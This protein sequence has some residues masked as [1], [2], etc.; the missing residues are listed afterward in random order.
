MDYSTEFR[1]EYRAKEKNS[2]FPYELIQEEINE[3]NFCTNENKNM[4]I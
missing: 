1:D 4:L 2:V 3:S